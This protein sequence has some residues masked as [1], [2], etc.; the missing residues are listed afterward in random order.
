MRPQM[1]IGDERKNF[2]GNYRRGKQGWANRKNPTRALKGS[3]SPGLGG[4]SAVRTDKLLLCLVLIRCE[5]FNWL[6]R[7]S[8]L[9][10]T[11]EGKPGEG[12]YLRDNPCNTPI[13]NCIKRGTINLPA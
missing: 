8:S 1:M 2:W 13:N 6:W 12:F 7:S 5:E 10:N 3:R 11:Y 4:N 9:P